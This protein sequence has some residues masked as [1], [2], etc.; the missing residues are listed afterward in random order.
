MAPLASSKKI[1]RN[2]SNLIQFS[3]REKD[4]YN[5]ARE[6]QKGTMRTHQVSLTREQ[7][8]TYPRQSGRKLS[9][10]ET[11]RREFKDSVIITLITKYTQVKMCVYLIN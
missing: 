7:V 9:P 3:D 4:Q 11:V 6:T 5:V 1:I 10:G 2:F 8:C